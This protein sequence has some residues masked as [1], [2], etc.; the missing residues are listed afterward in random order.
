[1]RYRELSSEESQMA[2]RHV[3]N[4]ST[5]LVIREIQIKMTLRYHLT[6][7]RMANIKNTEGSLYWKGCGIRETRLHCWWECKLVQPLWKSIWWLLRKLG[8][9]LLQD[10][11]D[12]Q[13]YHKDNSSTM[14]IEA[15][16]VIAKTWKQPGCPATE[17]WIN[18]MW[19][20]ME[21]YS[22]GEKNHIMKF[23]GKWIKLEKNPE[24]GDPDS[25][26]QTWCVLTHK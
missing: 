1:M 19:Y 26:R 15:L 23:A 2:E 10:P 12:T 9:N 13:S 21:H 20:T 4:C 25:E 14:F 17:A 16:F 6:P 11:K 8:I 22:A 7:V 3:R 5:S 24:W 18:K